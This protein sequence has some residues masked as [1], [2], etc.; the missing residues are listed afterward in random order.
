MS[1]VSMGLQLDGVTVRYPGSTHTTLLD[2]N[3]HV[4]AGE[5]MVVLGAS[6]CGKSS[7]LNLM[8][9]FLRPSAGTLRLHGQEITG[10]GIERGVVFQKYALL[11]WLS[12]LENVALGL[13]LQGLNATARIA[14]A[15]QLLQQLGL[16]D[17]AQAATWELSGGMQQRVGIARALLNDPEIL[18]MDE[19]FGAL[20]AFTREHLQGLLVQLW[21]QRKKTIVLIT[22]DVE[23][24]LF[25]ASRLVVLAPYPGRVVFQQNIDFNQRY[26][27]GESMRAIKSDPQFIDCREGVLAHIR[28][29]SIEPERLL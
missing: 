23:E 28:T 17:Y 24:A 8:A 6:G 25:L 10:P 29:S 2:I 20:D 16:G 4:E 7:L 27:A 3:L 19:P 5:L 18:L 11:P 26:L 12:V 22:H 14:R 21:Q 1:L 9:G 13:R 15:E